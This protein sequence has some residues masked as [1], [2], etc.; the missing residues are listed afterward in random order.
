MNVSRYEVFL[1]IL[2]TG[3]LTAAAEQFGCTQANV[4]HIVGGMEQEFGFKLLNRGRGGVRLTAEGEALLPYISAVAQAQASLKEKAAEI[5][6]R[7]GVTIRIGAFSSVSVHWLPGIIKSYQEKEPGIAF[8]L[9]SGDY[10]D[11]D[12]W[13]ESGSVDVAFITLPTAVS[14]RSIPLKEDRL[15]AVL[16]LNHRLAGGQSVELAQ[17][18]QEDFIT[19]L[20]TS[21]QDSRR[22]LEAAGI[23]PRVR[24]TTKDDYAIIAMVAGG[25]GISV[26]PEL[27]LKNAADNVKILP[28][29]PPAS[30]TIAL[31]I[32]EVNAESPAVTAFAAFVKRYVQ[33]L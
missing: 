4:S 15:M 18:A 30:R 2:E 1:K 27:L 3:G 26:M 21:D 7:S 13:L 16:P 22:V 25:L 28:L 29:N 12:M 6:S 10:H 20:E 11:V 31:A 19:L 14:C 32:P 24:F 8:K 17:T 5:A 9:L 23:K 33:E